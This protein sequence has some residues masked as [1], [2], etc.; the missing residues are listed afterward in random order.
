MFKREPGE[1]WPGDEVH[2]KWTDDNFGYV[3]KE[4][5]FIVA[6]VRIEYPFEDRN[7][8]FTFIEDIYGES[9]DIDSVQVEILKPAI[10]PWQLGFVI[11]VSLDF[12]LIEYE[13]D[14]TLRGMLNG[15]IKLCPGSELNKWS[16]LETDESYEGEV[17]EVPWEFELETVYQGRVIAAPINFYEKALEDAVTDSFEPPPHTEMELVDWQELP[18]LDKFF[19]HLEG[20]SYFGPGNSID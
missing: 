2:V 13:L 8:R 1:I 3:K 16:L 6:R 11:L 5:S 9:F 7:Y 18:L 10:V 15:Q 12:E 19:F 20:Y 14:E 4:S 17:V